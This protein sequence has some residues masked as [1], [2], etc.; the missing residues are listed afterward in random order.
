MERNFVNS[1]DIDKKEVLRYLEYNG[2]HIDEKLDYIIDECIKITK[3]KINPRYTLG[4]YSILKEKIDNSYQIKFKDSNISIK[5][6]DLCKL[7][8]SCRQCIVLSATL[9]IDIEKQIKINSYSNLTK[10]IIID[11]CA[12]TA[13]EEFCDILQSNIEE[14]LRKEGKYITNRYSPGYGDL[15]IHINEDIINLLNTSKKI[16]L[17]ITKDKI[18]IPRKSVIAIIGIT[19]NKKT[20]KQKSCSECSNYNTC[21][22]KKEGDNYGCKGIHKKQ[23]TDI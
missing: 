15:P 13:I 4:V 2:Q 5:S 16:G 10:S 12:T 9:G 6:K 14:K 17:T 22:Y 11:A 18:M 19:E 23:Y 20:Y 8:D 7:L 3:E 21:K 1:I